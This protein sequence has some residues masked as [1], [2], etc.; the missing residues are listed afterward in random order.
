[1][2]RQR[3]LVK[4]ANVCE[5][6]LLFVRT[7]LGTLLQDDDFA[8]LLRSEGLEV[9]PQFASAVDRRPKEDR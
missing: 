7:A 8:D 5:T 6:R 9:P 4:K 1:M 2:Q 3:N